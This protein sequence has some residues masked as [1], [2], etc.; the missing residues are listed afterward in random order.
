MRWGV[1]FQKLI[2][3]GVEGGF[4]APWVSFWLSLDLYGRVGWLCM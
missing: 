1:V 2:G 4:P 3:K